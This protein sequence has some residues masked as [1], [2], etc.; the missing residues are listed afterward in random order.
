M[1]KAKKKKPVVTIGVDSSTT[2]CG[3]AVFED[4]TLKMTCNHKFPGTYSLDKLR[5]ITKTFESIFDEH[6]PSMVILETPAP[7]RNSK[8][9]TALNQV[10]GAIW[11]TAVTRDIFIDDM[12]NKIIKKLMG[13]KT[14][15]DAIEK[16]EELFGIKVE[17]D[18]EADA[19]LT[20]EAYRIH[21]EQNG[22]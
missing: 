10:A 22:L 19:V 21:F 1:P 17:T 8:T 6:S 9:L 5:D 15:E 16:V 4:G 12:H 2:N 11:A 14:K 20:V 3:I 18:H 13:T 7:V